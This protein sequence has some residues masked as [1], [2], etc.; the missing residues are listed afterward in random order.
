MAKL[1]DELYRPIVGLVLL[2]AAIQ[3][4]WKPDRTMRERPHVLVLMAAGSALGLLAGRTGTGG[5]IFLSPLLLLTG[6]AAPRTTAAVAA[7][8]ILVNS[9]AGLAGNVTALGELPEGVGWL[10]IA[11]GAGG[12]LG[13][14]LGAIMVSRTTLMRLLALVL[15]IA[16]TKLLLT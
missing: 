13:S 11:V 12:L 4:A 3:F 8:F 5:G 10:A 6:W 9:L 16:G 1:S 7:A 15:V 2:V 14:R